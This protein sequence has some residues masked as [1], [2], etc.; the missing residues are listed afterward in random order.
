MKTLAKATLATAVAAT[1]A[2]AAGGSTGG[3]PMLIA[4]F[5]GFVALIIAFQF[6]PAVVLLGGM[7]KGLFSARKEGR[8]AKS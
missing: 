2:N 4:A 5:C 8:E 6:V 3:S 7:L 1:P